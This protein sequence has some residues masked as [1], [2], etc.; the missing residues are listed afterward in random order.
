MKLIFLNIAY[1]RLRSK[2][3]QVPQIKLLNVEQIIKFAS[4]L[5]DI[6]EYL[7]DITK[8]IYQNYLY[9]QLVFHLL[10]LMI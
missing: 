10:S 6:L 3:F 8:N 7:A 5:F 4:T 9:K 1:D 2:I